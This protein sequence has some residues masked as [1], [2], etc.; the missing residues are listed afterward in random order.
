MALS[1]QGPGAGGFD[2][3]DSSGLTDQAPGT[4]GGFA[5]GR[6]SDLTEQAPG[7]G[8]TLDPNE[9]DLTDLAPGETL[10]E[11]QLRDFGEFAAGL[12]TF[13]EKLGSLLGFGPDITGAVKRGAEQADPA[14]FS[15]G[16]KTGLGFE[17]AEALASLSGLPASAAVGIIDRVVS[18]VSN[19]AFAAGRASINNPFS[20]VAPAAGTAAGIAASSLPLARAVELGLNAAGIATQVPASLRTAEQPSRPE[21]T[22]TED[23]ATQTRQVAQTQPRQPALGARIE[24]TTTQDFERQRRTLA[25]REELGRGALTVR[26]A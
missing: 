14:A 21:R 5:G 17:A 16:Q 2:R 13:S 4:G 7:L 18:A 6:D 26:R 10:S 12:D 23:S 3:D 11:A 19:P 25:T 20:Q 24:S 22:L 15:A 8:G 9:T 1:E